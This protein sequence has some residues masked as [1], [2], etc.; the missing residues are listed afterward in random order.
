LSYG[1]A[2]C[3]RCF[4][5]PGPPAALV[6]KLKIEKLLIANLL[7]AIARPYDSEKQ[8]EEP[9]YR[10]ML[11]A[12]L[13]F[14]LPFWRSARAGQRTLDLNGGWRMED[15]GWRMEDAGLRKGPVL[16]TRWLLL[17]LLL[18]LPFPVREFSNIF[19]LL[20]LTSFVSGQLQ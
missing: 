16:S 13:N 18:L 20:R 7:P 5:Y 15:G 4:A 12:L 14:R 10:Y 9:K 17:L 2:I 6:P 1:W 11:F 19:F 3:A 8:K